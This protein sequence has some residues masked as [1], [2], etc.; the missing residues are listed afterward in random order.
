MLDVR[1]SSSRSVTSTKDTLAS[2]AVWRCV[3]R[4]GVVGYQLLV[5]LLFPRRRR[6]EL[7]RDASS[8]SMFERRLLRE[9][10]FIDDRPTVA[11]GYAGVYLAGDS[12]NAGDEE[13]VDGA[14]SEVLGEGSS[15]RSTFDRRLLKD[16]V[17]RD[18]RLAVARWYSGVRECDSWTGGDWDG[19][20]ATE[21]SSSSSSS[22]SPSHRRSFSLAQSCP[23]PLLRV[24]EARLADRA[25]SGDLDGRGSSRERVDDAP[26]KLQTRDD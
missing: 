3:E 4:S 13:G 10:V 9:E 5:E 14:A 2:L 24:T 12:W 20:A 11:R 16:V 6:R 8:P 17:F 7:L 26:R 19:V 22:S 21:A 1:P 25:R 23:A 15:S 18:D